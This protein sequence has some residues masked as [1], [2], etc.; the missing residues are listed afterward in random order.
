[1][2]YG[3]LANSSS[4]NQQ[5]VAAYMLSVTTGANVVSR[6]ENIIR[7]CFKGVTFMKSDDLYKATSVSKY[8]RER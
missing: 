7:A 4:A 8:A 3:T 2:K 5:A 6:A 1:M